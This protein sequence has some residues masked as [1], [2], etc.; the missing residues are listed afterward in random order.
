MGA[1]FQALVHTIN[2][3]AQN[4]GSSQQQKMAKG[5]GLFRAQINRSSSLILKDKDMAFLKGSIG[6]H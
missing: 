6:T 5:L 4:P 1:C 2:K 3:V